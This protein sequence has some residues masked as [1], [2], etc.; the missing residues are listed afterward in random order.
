MPLVPNPIFM[1][2]GQSGDVSSAQVQSL[3]V[4]INDINT[5]LDEISEA[6]AGAGLMSYKGLAIAGN[7][8]IGN[9]LDD[10]FD[11]DGSGG[12]ALSEIPEELKDEIVTPEDFSSMANL[13]QEHSMTVIAS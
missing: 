5:K 8:E 7:N 11:G 3:Q 6:L 12:Q 4:Q 9:A 2:Y 10:I 13:R 1:F